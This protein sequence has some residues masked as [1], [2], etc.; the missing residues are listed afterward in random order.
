MIKTPLGE[1][2]TLFRKFLT[3]IERLNRLQPKSEYD[4]GFIYWDKKKEAYRY[5]YENDQNKGR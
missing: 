3:D 4:D 1:I 5:R 2:I